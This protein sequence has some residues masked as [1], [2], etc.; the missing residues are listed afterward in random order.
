MAKSFVAYHMGVTFGVTW[1]FSEYFMH[2]IAIGGF[3]PSVNGSPQETSK[4]LYKD[5]EIADKFQ[6]FYPECPNSR[7]DCWWF[8]NPAPVEVGSLSND[9]QGSIHPR[10]CR[11][12]SI[13]STILS[14]WPTVVWKVKDKLPGNP[15]KK[16]AKSLLGETE[17]TG[18]FVSVWIGIFSTKVHWNLL[19]NLIPYQ[20]RDWY[21]YLHVPEESTKCRVIHHAGMGWE[22]QLPRN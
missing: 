15:T 17:R 3:F 8:R 10:W 4:W 7:S 14:I 5:C 22:C 13:N 1:F 9:L 16:T 21:M 12:S 6:S 2:T 20:A 11:I 18:G 19:F